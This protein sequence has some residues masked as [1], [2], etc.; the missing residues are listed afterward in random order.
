MSAAPDYVIE[1]ATRA[2]MVAEILAFYRANPEPGIRVLDEAEVAQLVADGAFYV[3]REGAGGPLVGTVY[4]SAQGLVDE[5]PEYE[6]GGGLVTAAHRKSGL[7]RCMAVCGLVAFRLSVRRSETDPGTD[8]A[9]VGRVEKSNTAP[10]R[11]VLTGL[12]FDLVGERRID[13]R[14]KK[15]LLD[16]PADEHG[17]VTVDQFEF[18]EA[19][20]IDRVRETLAYRDAGVVGKSGKTVSIAIPALLPQVGGDP[21]GQ[22]LGD[23]GG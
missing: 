14:G 13:T 1:A 3:A 19:N 16:M 9:I 17:F 15:G 21:L 23:L 10:V 20:L 7:V 2:T 12:G 22:L 8:V 11:Q 4:F 6:I 18:N 5:R